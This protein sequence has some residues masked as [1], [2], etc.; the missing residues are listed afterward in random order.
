MPSAAALVDAALSVVRA[1][2]AAE[3]YR[4]VCERNVPFYPVDRAE[5]G[6]F[7]SDLWPDVAGFA[8]AL[9][10]SDAR[11]RRSA[12][13]VLVT[14][15]PGQAW[16]ILQGLLEAA[17]EPELRVTVE[18]APGLVIPVP[19]VPDPVLVELLDDPRFSAP[20]L[21]EAVLYHRRGADE[22]LRVLALVLAKPMS[23]ACW[24][25]GESLKEALRKDERLLPLLRAAA[26]EDRGWRAWATGALGSLG[27]REVLEAEAARLDAANP[28]PA[29]NACI[30]L[31]PAHLAALEGRFLSK[32]AL[33][34]ARGRALGAS[35]LHRI[36]SA[37]VLRA[38]SGPAWKKARAT[39]ALAE[40][41]ADADGDAVG[42][43]AASLLSVLSGKKPLSRERK[44]RR[45]A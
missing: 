25:L 19:N 16:P 13:H 17:P 1:L 32:E 3:V 7:A 14:V 33:R 18:A 27:D 29:I 11:L 6:V 2:P 24:R 8:A 39:R 45:K 41:L 23:D 30:E 40:R 21:T 28:Q 34:T 15:A 38:R 42:F 35:V 26:A 31:G 12:P 9:A 5:D 20:A 37:I 10:C 4:T 44:P 36:E 22:R 43:A